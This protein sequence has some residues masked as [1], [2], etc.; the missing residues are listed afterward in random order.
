MLRATALAALTPSARRIMVGN[1]I[2]AIGGGLT[3]PFLVIYLG[4]VRN[5]GTGIAAGLVAYMALL[6]LAFTP[7]VG[8]LVDRIG[9]R[10][11]LMA[12]LAVI[13]A[14]TAAL[15]FARTLPQIVAAITFMAVGQS[16]SWAP[17]TALYARVTPTADRQT[18]FGLQFMLLNL[19]L[20][21]GGIIAATIVD[22]T[23]PLTFSLLYLL[24]AVTALAYLAV[25]ATLRGVG[26]GPSG[27]PR[28][29]DVKAGGYREVLRDRALRWLAIGS[30]ILL[31]FGY[32]SLEVGLPTYLTLIGGLEPS[33]V[34]FAYVANTA[35]IVLAQLFVIKRIQGRSRTRLAGLVGLMWAIA[36]LLVGISISFPPAIA[37][38]VACLGV[39]VFAL[40]ET[41]WSPVYPAIVNDLAS[42]ELRGRYNAVS[43]W[44]WGLA[45]TAGPALA[46]GLLGIGHPVL[47]VAVVVSGCLGA[48]ILLTGL[49][50]LLTIAQD[51]RVAA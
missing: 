12:G 21:I 48:G 23:R 40:G 43:A 3:L 14:A 15:A 42:D 9:P 36:W 35:V 1:G 2:A 46:A 34:A 28:V 51:G 41:I 26:V 19:G 8:T 11:V 18:V 33:A 7:P 44:T 22:V 24:N 37:A 30:C 47:W 49:R 25:L 16:A 20:G 27:E 29:A 17:Q 38:G 10:P 45:G 31:V 13:G 4:Q 32:G 5:L 50:R 6:G 39:A